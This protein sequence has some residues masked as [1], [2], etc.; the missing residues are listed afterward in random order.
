MSSVYNHINK[1]EIDKKNLLEICNIEFKVYFPLIKF[2][3]KKNFLSISNKMK[4]DKSIFF[5]FPIYLNIKKK[6][7][8]SCIEGKKVGL[9]FKENKVCDYLIEEKYSLNMNEKIKNGKKI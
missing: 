6:F 3:N 2:V 5:P 9:Y 4:F 8:K 7:D 1:I